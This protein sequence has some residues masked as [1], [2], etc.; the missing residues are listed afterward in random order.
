[1]FLL[2][3]ICSSP[4]WSEAGTI[5]SPIISERVPTGNGW[6]TLKKV[7]EGPADESVMGREKGKQAMG[8]QP[9]VSQIG[10]GCH[11]SFRRGGSRT[12]QD[13][14][15]QESKQWPRLIQPC[16]PTAP[17][18]GTK[19]LDIP[20]FPPSHILVVPFTGQNGSQ[21][22]PSRKVSFPGQ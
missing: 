2:K 18:E 17:W 5:I 15:L 19:Y 10:C 20:W 16:H 6:Y 3:P 14:T 12:Q 9:G 21:G 11:P 7:V 22:C 8:E 1:M 13:P 4:L